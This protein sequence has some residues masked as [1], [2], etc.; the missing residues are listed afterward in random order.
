MGNKGKSGILYQIYVLAVFGLIIIGICTYI[1]QHEIAKEA[2]VSQTETFMDEVADETI[3]SIK[4]YPGYK[5]LLSYWY[6]HADELEIEYDVDFRAGTETEK[7]TRLFSERHPDLQ[8]KYLEATEIEALPKEDQKLYAEI[9]YSWMTTRM[10]Q[11]KQ[12]YHLEFLFCLA[13]DTDEGKH[14][15]ETQFFYLSGAEKG[16]VRGTKYEQVYPLGKVSSVQKSQSGAM[17]E[18]VA[19]ADAEHAKAYIADAGSYMDYYAY[20]DEFGDQAVLIG[21]TEDLS[22]IMG[23]VRNQTVQGAA[24]AIMYQVVLLAIL[25]LLLVVTVIRPLRKVQG[26]IRL[27]TETKD[28][29][30]VIRNLKE[31]MSGFAVYFTRRNEIGLLSEDVTAMTDEIDHYITR[32][33]KITAEKERIGV[34]LELAARIQRNMLPDEYPAFPE[35]EEFELFA[36]MTPAREVGGDFYDY[37]MI[38]E[39]HLV[40][41]IADVSGKG[42]PAALLMMGSKIM[43]RNLAMNELSPA[44]TL[45][46]ANNDLCENNTEE[47]FVTVWLGVLELSTGKLT[48]ANAGHEYPVYKAANGSFRLFRDK[49]GIV[50]GG[51]PGVP[52]QDYELMMEPGSKL[53]VYTDGLT[54]ATGKN[55]EMFGT[56]RMVRVLRENEDGMPEEILQGMNRAVSE[57]TEGAEQFDDLT[58]LCVEYKGRT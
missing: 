31:L 39:D 14:P 9:T 7:K 16:S 28:R 57:F 2:V 35:Q 11:I 37:F 54:E 42:I 38:D 13:T 52:Y 3:A 36:A 21:L 50:I 46:T 6:E 15:Y 12:N 32:I 53:F 29:E 51:M 34:E 24:Y 20:L 45:E 58:M 40:L 56:E 4:E 55:R 25:M 49:H 10:N 19:N 18:A 44:R 1:S 33:E 43:L 8:I 30:T 23:D 47:M 17:R 26:N 41:L 5:W 48:A 22:E 27:Y